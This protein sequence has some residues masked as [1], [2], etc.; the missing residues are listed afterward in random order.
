VG[1]VRKCP[2]RRVTQRPRHPEVDQ[3]SATRLEPNNQVLAATPDLSHDLA[4]E[5]LR[6][7]RG[8]ER[9][10]ESFV[11]DLDVLETPPLEH[12]CEPTTN[13]LDLGQLGHGGTVAALRHDLEEDAAPA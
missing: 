8:R 3:E 10:S 1:I 2:G 12:G 13:A 9:P 7:L 11:G 4:L 6:H 5:S